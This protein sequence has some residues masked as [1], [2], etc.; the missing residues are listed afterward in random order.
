MLLLL[1][2]LI[3]IFIQIEAEGWGKT[4][5]TPEKEESKEN[6]QHGLKP[7]AQKDRSV[8]TNPEL[9][10]DILTTATYGVTGILNPTIHVGD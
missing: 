9:S 10:Q 8:T 5:T 2:I 7:E 4:W 6:K 3:L 1:P